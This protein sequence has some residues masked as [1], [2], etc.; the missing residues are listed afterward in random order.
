MTSVFT[1]SC[2]LSLAWLEELEDLG[3]VLVAAAAQAHED[4]LRV[5]VAGARER[6]RRLEGR[7]DPLGPGEVGERLQRLLVGRD[8][9]LGAPGVAQERVL[10][11][12]ARIVEA[13][14]D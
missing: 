6:V 14:R 8:A 13:G 2:K 4:Q 7:D 11:P 1:T 3:E 10:R 12:D 9:V 5:Q